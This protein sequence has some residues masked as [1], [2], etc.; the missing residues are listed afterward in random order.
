MFEL[1]LLWCSLC[2]ASLQ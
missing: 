1:D 2:K